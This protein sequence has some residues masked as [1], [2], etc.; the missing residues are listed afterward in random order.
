[1][2]GDEVVGVGLG[3]LAGEQLLAGVLATDGIMLGV[4]SDPALGWA[5][6]AAGGK[7]ICW[8]ASWPCTVLCT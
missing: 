2:H 8:A 3:L 4:I 6:A 5:N 7:V 1:M